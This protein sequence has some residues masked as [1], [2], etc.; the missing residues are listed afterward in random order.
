[1]RISCAS[2]GFFFTQ[3][4]FHFNTATQL[5][6]FPLQQNKNRPP[7]NAATYQFRRFTFWLYSLCKGTKGNCVE[8]RTEDILNF[9]RAIKSMFLTSS[10][11]YF[12][13]L[14]PSKKKLYK[15]GI[16]EGKVVFVYETTE[17]VGLELQ[18]H[19]FLTSALYESQRS[20][21]G[22]VC[23][24]HGKRAHVTNGI[25]EW[26]GSGALLTFRSR[27]KLFRPARKLITIPPLCTIRILVTVP[28]RQS[29][30]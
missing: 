25:G 1:M 16:S 14:A 11:Q 17:K 7:H 21:A 8:I 13:V 18:L 20:A 19:S 9:S 24:S 4:I 12:L 28:T 29:N 2:S 15:F 5:T 23:L 6:Y 30:P 3:Q 10:W 27:Y 26:V 22:R